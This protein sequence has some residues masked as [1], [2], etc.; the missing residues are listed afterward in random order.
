M[1]SVTNAVSLRHIR[2]HQY[3]GFIISCLPMGKDE[4]QIDGKGTPTLSVE[5]VNSMSMTQSSNT[6]KVKKGNYI[7]PVSVHINEGIQF[8]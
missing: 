5:Y 1:M 8:L 4:G 6:V 7:G 2:C 3:Q